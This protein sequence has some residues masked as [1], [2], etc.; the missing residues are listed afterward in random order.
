MLTVTVDVGAAA[1]DHVVDAVVVG[2]QIA[3]VRDAVP[4][5]VLGPFLGVRDTVPV[6]VQVLAVRLA[7]AVSVDR[8]TTFGRVRDAVPVGVGEGIADAAEDRV[9][10]VDHVGRAVAIVVRGVVEQ[11]V[12]VGVQRAVAHVVDVVAG[13]VTRGVTR[14]VRVRVQVIGQRVAV[15]VRRRRVAVLAVA[16]VVVIGRVDDAVAVGVRPIGHAVVV[17]IGRAGSALDEVGHAVVVAVQ[18]EE[19]GRA[20]AV[21]VGHQRVAAALVG[22]DAGHQA[23]AVGVG[24]VGHAVVVG[25]GVLEDLVEVAVADATFDHVVDAVVVA[26]QIAG[27]GNPVAVGVVVALD[28]VEDAV[29]VVIRVGHVRH[30]VAV[31]VDGRQGRRYADVAELGRIQVDRI[32]DAVAVRVVGVVDPAV[33]VQVQIAV[34]GLVDVQRGIA[35]AV[36][37]APVA[38]AVVVQVGRGRAAGIAEAV[39]TVDTV[40]D[41]VAVR[42]RTVDD[43]IVIGVEAAAATLDQ[44]GDA[45]VVAVQVAQVGHAVAVAVDRRQRR[46]ALAGVEAVQNAVAVDVQRVGLRAG[47]DEDHAQL[48]DVAQDEVVDGDRHAVRADHLRVELGAAAHAAAVVDVFAHVQ[49]VGRVEIVPAQDQGVDGCIEG[50]AAGGAAR[51]A[52]RVPVHQEALDGGAGRDLEGRA[53]GR[54][55]ATGGHE[56]VHVQGRV[57]HQGLLF[58]DADV[59]ALQGPDAEVGEAGLTLLAQIADVDVAAGRADGHAQGARY[60]RAQ[61][62]DHAVAV[63]VRPVDLDHV[64]D[65][66]VVAVQIAAVRH[67]VAVRVQRAIA[68]EQVRQ[69][70]V[71]VVV[72]VDIRHAVAVG[73][74]LGLDGEGQ[75][76]AVLQVDVRGQVVAVV[77]EREEGIAAVDGRVVADDHPTQVGGAQGQRAR[78]DAH[79]HLADRAG[80]GDLPQPLDAGDVRRAGHRR[81]DHGRAVVVAPEQEAAV[82]GEVIG[83]VGV[84]IGQGAQADGQ[85]PVQASAG[86]L[87]LHQIGRV[88]A[89]DAGHVVVEAL[90]ARVA[91]AGPDRRPAR[92][93][94]VEV[95]G[96]AGRIHV[97]RGRPAQREVAADALAL[98]GRQVAVVDRHLADGTVPDL[99]RLVGTDLELVGGGCAVGEVAFAQLHVRSG[100]GLAVEDHVQPG[101]AQDARWLVGHVPFPAPEVG[102][103]GHRRGR[104]VG[105]DGRGAVHVAQRRA[106]GRLAQVRVVDAEDHQVVEARAGALV[107]GRA[108]DRTARLGAGHEGRQL[109]TAVDAVEEQRRVEVRAGLGPLIERLASGRLGRHVVAVAALVQPGVHLA[110]EK[111]RHALV[112]LHPELE[113]RQDAAG[114]VADAGEAEILPVAQIDHRGGRAILVLDQGDLGRRAGIEVGAVVHQQVC[115]R[116]PDRQADLHH[117][118]AADFLDPPD[119]AHARHR[120]RRREAVG[121][122]GVAEGGRAVVVAP[123]HEVLVGGEGRL[124]LDGRQGVGVHAARDPLVQA[125]AVVA[126]DAGHV[127][128]VVLIAG[129][130]RAGPDGRPAG[131]DVVVVDRVAGRIDIQRHAPAQREVA[132]DA[133]ALGRAEVAV[134]DRHLTDRP[135]PGFDALVGA[136]LELV[137]GGRAV[138]EL[139]LAHL[140]VGRGGDLAVEDHVQSGVADQARRLAGHVPF[141]APDMGLARHRIGRMIVADGRGAVHVAQGLAGHRGRAQMRVVDTED[142]QIVEAGARAFVGCGAEDRTARLGAGHEGRDLQSIVAA[143]EEQGRME[144]GVGHRA[145]VGGLAGGRLG[146]HVVAVAALVQPGVHRAALGR[147]GTV[148]GQHP[149]LEVGRDAA[150]CHRGAREAEVLAIGQVHADA[151]VAVGVHRERKL[152]RR[153]GVEVGAAMHQQ[154]GGA[155][156]VGNRERDRGDAAAFLDAPDAIHAGVIGHRG[157]AVGHVGLAEGHRA[158]VVAP[159]QEA[160]VGQEAPAL[161]HGHQGIG[162][163]AARLALVQARVVV[164]ADAGHVV[165]VGGVDRRIPNRVASR[166]DV[167]ALDDAGVVVDGAQRVAVLDRQVAVDAL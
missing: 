99:D 147:A 141:P 111:G 40:L 137:R 143:V 13:S 162:M 78:V 122:I 104:M 163:D 20:V 34:A 69:A 47:I 140:H 38:V 32:G 16:G 132:V 45:V 105:P 28:G 15:G 138:G 112:G 108:V 153:A 48:V 65:A 21:R 120:R 6:R 19:V 85:Q 119:A 74:D 125:R 4:V 87:P 35:I 131:V 126:A 148:V 161:L 102:L 9:V 27:V 159:N 129:V 117:A 97:Q 100:E 44:V 71:V 94:V 1:L 149:E 150:R 12:A 24:A 63:G 23:V 60:H 67:A 88:V 81:R 82:G 53:A 124:G 52:R 107:G 49:A 156:A 68:L 50:D 167:V 146:R 30:A 29:V 54:G 76:L 106:T 14:I 84:G 43:A 109:E 7:V 154:V 165:V 144:V 8:A 26:V 31:G 158:V 3:V 110:T 79:A 17:G 39:Q 66:V 98:D 70:V 55:A 25:V 11:A 157:E 10:V 57:E 41:A 118:D 42:V 136:D 152:E 130:G 80:L 155:D 160:A 139:A 2:V 135:V 58:E 37:I 22:V 46:T 61:A 73:V 151:E 127:V 5:R 72:I 116:G 75:D 83:V 128:V 133:L 62:V 59:G 33:V 142:D 18:V 121:R 164:A 123:E 89:T 95:G 51:A 145:L 92:V 36:D 114:G 134:V 101:V 91:R 115:G 64:V 113:V 77:A 96:G 103:V 56:V 86:R 90:V 93:G 166:V